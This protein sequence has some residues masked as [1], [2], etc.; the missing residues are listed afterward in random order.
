MPL[1]S[2]RK[3]VL[4]LIIAAAGSHMVSLH[5]ELTTN[6]PTQTTITE[7]AKSILKTLGSKEVRTILVM[8][9]GISVLYTIITNETPLYLNIDLSPWIS[10]HYERKYGYPYHIYQPRIIYY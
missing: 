8:A 2:L 5:A 1:L 9:L 3:F 6:M 10:F 4:S 7:C